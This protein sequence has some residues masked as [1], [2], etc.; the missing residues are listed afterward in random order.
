MCQATLASLARTAMAMAALARDR[1]RAAL[2][3]EKKKG[4]G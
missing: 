1:R 2:R 3:R 4:K